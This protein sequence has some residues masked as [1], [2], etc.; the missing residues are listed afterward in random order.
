MSKTQP[1]GIYPFPANFLLLPESSL[2]SDEHARL[3][4]GEVPAEGTLYRAA[5]DGDVAGALALCEDDSNE[6]KFNRFVLNSSPEL[7]EKLKDEL[8]GASASLLE[9]AAFTLSYTQ[10]PPSFENTENEIRALVLTARATYN[11]ES[12][13]IEAALGELQDARAAAGV[14]PVF[15]GQIA[16]NLAETKHQTAGA[17]AEVVTLYKA[18]IAGLKNSALDGSVA[19]LNLNLG[20]CYQEMSQGNRGALLEAVKHYQEALKHFSREQ[21][22]EEFAFTQNNLALAYL[23][24][25][26]TE[27]SDTLRVAIAIQALREALKVYKKDTH[28]ELWASTQLNLANALQYAPSGHV[29]ENLMES[30]NLYDEILQVRQASENPIGYARLLANQGNALAHLGVFDHAVAKLTEARAIFSQIGETDSADS[31]TELLNDIENRGETGRAA[32]AA[33]R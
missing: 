1:I 12:G 13:E 16:G 8:T 22:P 17:S 24:I 9:V 25:P 14:S 27:A 31:L 28:P 33:D 21:F 20:I 18:A 10:T 19:T 23:S 7:Y 30:V 32:A 2:G 4:R 26:L 3:L 29:E 11:L 15:A 6:S 5:L